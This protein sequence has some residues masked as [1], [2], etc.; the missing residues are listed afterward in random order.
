MFMK[1]SIV[2]CLGLLILVSCATKKDVLLFQDK[3]KLNAAITYKAPK[4]Q[5]NDI[6]N[7][8]VS[9]LQ[10]ELAAPYN[11]IQQTANNAV[12]VES[13][14]LQGYLVN[15]EGQI[16]FPV[17]GAI[18]VNDKT[19]QEL[20]QFLKA[21]LQDDNHLLAPTVTVRI[22]N[23]KV[24]IL[25]EV[26]HPGTFSYTEQN[27]SVLQ[28]IG[29]AGDLSIRGKRKEVLLIRELD[30]QRSYTTLDLTKTDW[31]T[32]EYFYI[33]QNDVLVVNPNSARIK[34]A[35]FIADPAT[36]LGVAS[37]ILS[38]VILLTR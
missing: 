5:V 19:P 9:T 15:A 11:L 23:S 1:K 31:F 26:M 27:I 36:L 16:T 21:K 20:E 25:G 13:L 12:I 14:K 4:I 35:G 29:L 10:P 18:K 30:G 7:V 8:Q 3:S 17:L 22:I 38:M 2:L 24:T 33:K 34:N 6:L 37:V 28:A 32:S